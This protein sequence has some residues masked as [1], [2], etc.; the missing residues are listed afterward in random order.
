MADM[1]HPLL[2]DR[3]LGIGS[4]KSPQYLHDV[5]ASSAGFSSASR[6]LVSHCRL[7]PHIRSLPAPS[8]APGHLLLCTAR[9]LLTERAMFLVTSDVQTCTKKRLGCRFS[10]RA[11]EIIDRAIARFFASGTPRSRW[12]SSRVV[13]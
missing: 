1:G 11:C 8:Q 3:R 2:P 5:L 9:G 7:R 4:Q 10:N 12:E 13:A 6:M